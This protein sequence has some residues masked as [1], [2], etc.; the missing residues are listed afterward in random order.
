MHAHGRDRAARRL[1]GLR[2]PVVGRNELPGRGGVLRHH[3]HHAAEPAVMQAFAGFDH[4]RMKAAVEADRQ[5]DAG[6]LRGADYGLRAGAVER[7]RLLDVD[8]L[9][10]LRRAITCSAWR[11]CGVASTTAS[12]DGSARIAS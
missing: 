10:G 6:L 12:I 2:A 9:A 5:H 3:R 8:V 7:Q 11:L 4:R 1:V